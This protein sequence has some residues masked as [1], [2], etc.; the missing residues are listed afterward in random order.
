MVYPAS[1]CCKLNVFIDTNRMNTGDKHL[2][3]IYHHEMV[4]N[5]HVFVLLKHNSISFYFNLISVHL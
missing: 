3:A 2:F 5:E 4:R 1:Q